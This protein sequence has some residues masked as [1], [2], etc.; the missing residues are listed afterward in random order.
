[1]R[2]LPYISREPRSLPKLKSEKDGF[3]ERKYGDRFRDSIGAC[4]LV[5]F[6]NFVKKT[7]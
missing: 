2:K 1:M 3:R 6:L 4:F 5:C 7:M